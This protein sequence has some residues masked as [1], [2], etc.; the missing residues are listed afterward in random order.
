MIR[1]L[2]LFFIIGGA[3][4]QGLWAQLE[5][6]GFFEV[7]GQPGFSEGDLFAVAAQW[8][9]ADP[10]TDFNQD[11]RVDLLDLVRQANCVDGLCHGLS[12]QYYGFEDG[13][14]GQAIS[15]PDFSALGEDYEPVVMRPT[16]YL[17]VFAGYRGFMDSEMR[18][19]FGA[20]YSGYLMV[21]ESA[22]YT[23]HVWGVRGMRVSLDGVPILEFDHP[24]TEEQTSV[25]L[26]YGLHPIEIEFY[27]AGS[28]ARILLDWASDGTVIGSTAQVVMPEFLYQA[29]TPVP[30][31]AVTALELLLDPPSGRR[32]TTA[33]LEMTA[34]AMGP[35]TD[36]H[37]FLDG[38]EL[39]LHDG[40]TV[41]PLHLEPGLN[42]WA[43]EV[44]DGMGRAQ[45]R[46]YHLYYDAEDIPFP[47]LS[48]AV[49]AT[50]GY[51]TLPDVSLL[52]P[53]A[54][55]D[56]PGTQMVEV[57]PFNVVEMDGRKLGRGNVVRLQGTIEIPQTGAYTFVVSDQSALRLDGEFICGIWA[58]YP[59]QW[60]SY[61]TVQLDAGR[62]HYALDVYDPWSGPEIRVQW[63]FE[64]GSLT[65]IP[66]S[67]FAHGPSHIAALPQWPPSATGN[68]V[69]DGLL[70]EYI[71]QPSARF[72]DTTGHGFDLNP[73]PRALPRNPGGVTYETGGILFNE[74][75]GVHLASCV[76]V[77]DAFSLEVD[78]I[79]DRP[80]AQ[81][82]R[83]RPLVS[84]RPANWGHLAGLDLI[85]DDISFYLLDQDGAAE[86]VR[87]ENVMSAGTRLHVVGTFDG[88]TL[89][90]TVNGVEAGSVA[91]DPVLDAWPNLANL[92]I[93][94]P[95]NRWA[96]SSIGDQQM[97]GTFL[98]AACYTRSLSLSEI[99]TNR[100]A[101]LVVAPDPDPLP[102]PSVV[103]FPPIGTTPAELDEAFHILNRLTFGPTPQTLLEVLEG[104]IDAWIAAQLA[105]QTLDDSVLETLLQA[106]LLRPHDLDRDFQ[107]YG[108]LRMSTSKRQLLE[109]LTQFWDNHFNT[110]MDKVD[111]FEQELAEN[112]MF[113]THALD[114]FEQLLLA[115]ATGYPMTVYLDNDA[116]VV[117]APNE[118]FAREILELFALGVN[119]GYT[120][121]DIVQAARC[122]TGWTVREGAFFFDPGLH[123]YGE[124]QLLGI[125]IPAGGGLEDGIVLIDHLAHMPEC[126]EFVTWK[127][128]QLFVADDPP[129]D[130]W[131]ATTTTFMN[132]GGDIA[133]VLGTLFQ[134]PQFRS[135]PD[136]R[137]NKV[138][139]PLE[140]VAGIARI[141]ES[142]PM[143]TG[144]ID[145]LDSMGMDLF[146]CV[147]P[148]GYAEEGAV[149]ID[150]NS[151][152]TRWNVVN[153]VSTNRGNG[154]SPGP[155]FARFIHQFGVTQPDEILDL[156]E[157]LTTHGHEAAGVR[158]L[159]EA[160]LTDGDPG[161][162][163]LT[164][165]VLDEQVRQTLGLYLRLPEWHK[166]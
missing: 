53:Y 10:I 127:L 3:V 149:W 22:G 13:T 139:T 120:Q 128:C 155:R 84:L 62:Y 57:A 83:R 107:A 32:V 40:M 142:F 114:D 119:N 151:L 65:D 81:D 164:D 19:Q 138:K 85:N 93:G 43:F 38:E 101:N 118:N 104:G 82:W 109:V 129:Q 67:A 102:P 123:D 18:H 80:S 20:V 30:Q 156:F 58:L 148:T 55:L 143:P 8:T 14:P 76:V 73:D 50:E 136:F 133:A 98:L 126:A 88:T 115:S 36:V 26:T 134:H 31:H 77:E 106:D 152:L 125:T 97:F 100:Q 161:S 110:Q 116:N 66:D 6:C 28:S 49:F 166:Q 69:P 1:P 21:P 78:F 99:E 51:E 42:T 150:T 162:F 117:G 140:F 135:D 44:A 48:A 5:P 141:T 112:E 137:Q 37:L 61:R 27:N 47:G 68:R 59:G 145:P 124:K 147:E 35:N 96:G 122:F 11:G 159:A 12:G 108:L 111:N 33:D 103:A 9:T 158:A 2:L 165:E 41:I 91:F 56:A 131:T 92:S 79:S 4:A 24:A 94:Q 130:I 121:E 23:L 74:Q 105:P 25:F 75:A 72:S 45:L 132:T 7:D 71:F 39:V 46:R 70:A 90:I 154:M 153:Q 89:R 160:W 64:S 163:V 86:E 157:A 54:V 60:S 113:R 144:L 17:A 63:A 146:N 29:A 87:A 52:Q 34:F 95:F 16:E 15:F